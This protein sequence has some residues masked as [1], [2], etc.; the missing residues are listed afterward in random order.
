MALP[1]AVP[2]TTGELLFRDYLE[3][4]GY[5]Y[6]FEKEFPSR[7]ARPDY[8]I[9]RYGVSLFDVKDFGPKLSPLGF[10]QFDPYAHLR[11]RIERGRKKF[12]EYKDFP[13]CVVLL[14]NG[15]TFVNS[16]NAAVVL[17]AMYGNVGFPIAPAD[18]TS[19]SDQLE[20]QPVFC[21]GGKMIRKGQSRNTTISA[22]ITLRY[23]AVGMCRYRKMLREFPRLS[24]PDTLGKA[25]ERFQDFNLDEKKL[26]VIVWE[27]AFARLPLS[28]HLF[29]GPYDERWGIDGADQA[30]VFRGEKLAE[31]SED[32]D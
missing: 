4:M 21:G 2:T 12:K 31:L 14:N 22:L 25:T 15:N 29:T 27:N 26:G 7:L 11:E 8:A 1:L 24:I 9:T 6:E 20:P 18:G 23:V 10:S 17:G 19:S 13:C 16:E 3:M 32:G 28:R 30:I 5:P